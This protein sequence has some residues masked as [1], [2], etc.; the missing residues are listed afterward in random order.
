MGAANPATPSFLNKLLTGNDFLPVNFT[1]FQAAKRTTDA[2][3]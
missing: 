2:R 3:K 1:L